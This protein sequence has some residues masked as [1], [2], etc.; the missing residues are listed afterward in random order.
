MKVVRLKK[1]KTSSKFGVVFPAN[2][3]LNCFV[4]S[5]NRI[6]AQ[7]PKHSNIYMRVKLEKK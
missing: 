5:E 4:D 7:H 2:V 6:F 1:E 3:D